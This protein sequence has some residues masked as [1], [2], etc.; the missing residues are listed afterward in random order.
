MMM[1][2]K[3]RGGAATRRSLIIL[4]FLLSLTRMLKSAENPSSLELS[5]IDG[6]VQLTARVI[7][8]RAVANQS[9]ETHSSGTATG[10]TCSDLCGLKSQL[11]QLQP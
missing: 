3:R 10:T 5:Q 2:I 4:V 1:T 7:C 9:L 11:L 6:S 8:S